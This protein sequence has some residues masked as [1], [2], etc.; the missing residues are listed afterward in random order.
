[1]TLYLA[2]SVRHD[3]HLKIVMPEEAKLRKDP[4]NQSMPREKND[5]KHEARESREKQEG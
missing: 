4:P 5:Q 2:F 1:M 3:L